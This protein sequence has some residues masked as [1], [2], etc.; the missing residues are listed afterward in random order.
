MKELTATLEFACCGCEET[1]RVTVHC[2]GP[3]LRRGKVRSL[4]SVNVPC[5]TCGQI[6]QLVFEPGGQ[7]RSV[8]PYTC[9]RVLPE[10]S[11]N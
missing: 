1:V 6:N 3:D 2:S 7:V 5:P 10:P 11:L 4:A 9:F 8:R